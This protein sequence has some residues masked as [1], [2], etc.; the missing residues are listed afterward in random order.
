M[1]VESDEDSL[2]NPIKVLTHQRFLYLINYSYSIH[3]KVSLGNPKITFNF[4]IELP[5]SLFP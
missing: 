3:T 5:Q 2:L 4:F 1:L